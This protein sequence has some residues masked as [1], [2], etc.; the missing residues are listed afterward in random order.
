MGLTALQTNPMSV[1]ADD[2]TQISGIGPKI[3]DMLNE[4]GIVQVEQ[5]AAVT[6]DMVDMIDEQIPRGQ[7]AVEDWIRQARKIAGMPGK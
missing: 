1:V 7:E 5:L 4:L 2:L 3:A 6:K